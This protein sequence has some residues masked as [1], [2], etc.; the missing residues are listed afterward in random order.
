[1]MSQKSGKQMIIR[2]IR[3]FMLAHET[4]TKAEAATY[5]DVSFP[6]VSKFLNQ[7]VACG[8]VISL[9]LAASSGGRRANQYQYNTAYML[10]MVVFLEKEET[11]YKVYDSAGEVKEQ[12]SW[13]TVLVAGGL[14][15]LVGRI[16]QV[17][18]IYPAIQS[19]TIGVP[20]VVDNGKILYI[21]DY[22]PFEGL[23]ISQHMATHFS[24]PTVV[25]NDMN[26]AVI[27][28]FHLHKL[29]DDK[30]LVYMYLGQ[31]GPGAGVI[32]NGRV[33]RGE[34]FFA[35]EVAFIPQYDRANFYQAVQQA[36]RTIHNDNMPLIDALSRLIAAITAI[37]NPY[38]II[39]CQHEIDQRTL[40]L[41]QQTSSKYMA[42]RHLP[43]LVL[44][45]WREDY[46][47]GLH[48]LGMDV[49]LDRPLPDY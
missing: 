33:H 15:V 41:I 18:A 36:G 2:G 16:S 43:K 34:T 9:G 46:L 4:I 28:Y 42:K 49:L 3:R 20:G 6:T 7:M 44:G 27:G 12:G 45:E 5:L 35:G 8:E 26:A 1:M 30:T 11:Y 23:D 37:I 13:P 48:H 29:K 47:F 22:P 38:L 31:N 25:E 32:I 14:E 40:Q 19:L 24:I 39:F 10:N 21:P 17:F